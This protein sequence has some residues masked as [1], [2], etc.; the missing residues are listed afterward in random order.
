[1]SGGRLYVDG[2]NRDATGNLAA[3]RVTV[4]TPIGFWLSRGTLKIFLDSR[5]LI[6]VWGD[7]RRYRRH[8]HRRRHHRALPL[9]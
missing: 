9:G 6:R 5:I 8:H 3:T 7:R 2:T 4:V 1:M